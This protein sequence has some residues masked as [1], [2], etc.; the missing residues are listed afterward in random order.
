MVLPKIPSAHLLTGT[1]DLATRPVKT[2]MTFQRRVSFL[3]HENVIAANID[4]CKALQYLVEPTPL[5]QNAQRILAPRN[6][7]SDPTLS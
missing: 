4:G 3:D 7:L 2:F 6:T 5:M 1:T